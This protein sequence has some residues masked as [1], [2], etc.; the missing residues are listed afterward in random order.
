MNVV[1]GIYAFLLGI[2]LAWICEKY[3]TIWAPI[4]F[5]AAANLLSVICTEWNFSYRMTVIGVLLEILISTA[6][7]IYAMVRISRTT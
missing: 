4:L 7:M 6:L 3:Q 5:H 1:Q 2:L